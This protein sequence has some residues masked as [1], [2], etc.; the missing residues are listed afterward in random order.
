[1][2]L[3][4]ILILSFLM[5]AFCFG[6]HSQEPKAS[7]PRNV[8]LCG[9]LRN[10]REYDN[11]I[12]RVRAIWRQ[13]FEWS[14]LYA[15]ACEG[16]VE[17]IW[18]CPGDDTCKKLQRYLNRHLKGDPMDGMYAEFTFVGRFKDMHKP[19]PR[20]GEYSFA[21]YITDM[22]GAK[23]VSPPTSGA[24]ENS[25]NKNLEASPLLLPNNSLDASGGS[26]FRN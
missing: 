23:R 16:Y 26:G 8:A 2:K 10:P 4:R 13:T 25:E 1:M 6:A 11:Q 12:V 14:N 19:K 21:L 3:H 5:F 18:D 17:P 20:F 7:S 22:T 15:T 9:L 24:R